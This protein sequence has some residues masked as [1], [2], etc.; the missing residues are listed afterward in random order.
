MVLQDDNFVTIRDAIAEGRGIFDNVKKFVN[1]LLSANAGEVLV[2]FF[3]I[4]LGTILFPE[5]FQEEAEALILTPI[6]LLWINLVTDGMPALA[7]GMDPKSD[8]IMD[9]EPRGAD[10]QVISKR[11]MYSILGMGSIMTLTGLPLFFY[12]LEVTGDLIIAQTL[13]FTFLVLVEMIR[14]QTIRRRYK[15]ALMTN[16]WLV[17]ALASSILLQLA[18]LYTP[19]R[20]FFGTAFLGV[21]EWIWMLTSVAGF[22]GITIGMI[23]LFNYKSNLE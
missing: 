1:Y 4:F 11:M 2:V 8:N 16:I 21:S 20:S 14:I 12:G 10:E 13:I 23:K 22:L 17:I 15:Q 9:R 7:L 18:V 5:I 6:M 3:G 19:L